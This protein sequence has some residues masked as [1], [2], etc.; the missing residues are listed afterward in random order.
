M[1]PAIDVYGVFADFSRFTPIVA[2]RVEGWQATADECSFRVKG[3]NVSLRI[4]EREPGKMIK[5]EGSTPFEFT[6]WMQLVETDAADEAGT[7]SADTRMRLVLHAEIP[8][9]VRMMLGSKLQSG[10]DD[11]ARQIAEIFNKMPQITELFS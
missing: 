4:T 10:L 7:A 2:D 8:M 3:F 5:F 9:M 1:R 6:L 11:A